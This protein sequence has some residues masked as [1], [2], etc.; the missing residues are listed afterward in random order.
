MPQPDTDKA[1]AAEERSQETKSFVR[2]VR[3]VTRRRYTPEE[4]IRIVLEGFRRE[5]TVNDLCR[6]EGS[7][8]TPTTRGPKSSWRP[9]RKGLPVMRHGTP[10]SMRY[11]SSSERTGNSGSWWPICH[12]RRTASKNGHPDPPRRHRY[13]RMSAAEKA[14]VLTKVTSS[15]LP[16]RKTLRELGIPKSTYYRW[17]RRKEHQGLEDHAGS[18]KP[19]WNR[20]TFQEVDY[21]VSA[22]REMPQLSCRQLAA[23]ITDNQGFSVSESSV[24]RILRREGLVK[25]P[26]MQLKAGKEY[27]RKTSGP[28]Q[29]WA[30]DASY[31]RVVGWGYYYLVTVM[32]DYSRFILAHRLQRDMTSDSFIEVV[33]EAVD[34]TG[35]DQ[36]AVTDRTRLL[37]D[38]GPGYVSRAFTGLPGDGRHQAHLGNPFSPSDQREARALPSDAQAGRKP[39]AL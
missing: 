29:M 14:E 17:L 37:S 23:W 21:V 7:S 19:T 9:A 12:W 34:R 36:V 33:Q 38:N 18:G 30:T 28:H 8:L 15:P 10:L 27:H 26:E 13:Q 39:G 4:K 32:D 24:Y 20:L 31:F 2:R 16:K 25:S 3:S 35:M 11:S 5:V 22:A 1:L 6:R